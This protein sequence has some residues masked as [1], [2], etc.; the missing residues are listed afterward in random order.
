LKSP[1]Q[2]SPKTGGQPTPFTSRTA[3]LEDVPAIVA[4]ERGLPSAAHWPEKTYREMFN[5][6][7]PARIAIVLE[8]AQELICGFV[9]ARL[10][11]GECEL[12]NIAVAPSSA[13]RGGGT[14]LL[15]SLITE[16]RIR[17]AKGI[18]LEVRESNAAARALYEKGGFTVV[19][20]RPRY[21]AE[22]EEDAILYSVHL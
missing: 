7:A 4:V 2:I 15:H 17:N 1:K 22:P 13:R 10:S 8:R 21:Y 11:S 9:I 18:F 20:R 3:T 5:P 19:G 6:D 12:E 16:A 14:H